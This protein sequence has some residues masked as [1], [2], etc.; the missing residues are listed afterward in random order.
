MKNPIQIA[1]HCINF[2]KDNSQLV[3]LYSNAR[4]TWERSGELFLKNAEDNA[5]LPRYDA[6]ELLGLHKGKTTKVMAFGPSLRDSYTEI[7]DCDYV[8]GCDRGYG[9]YRDHNIDPDLIITMDAK[10]YPEYIG[11][12]NI[13]GRVLL[14]QATSNHNFCKEWVNRGGKV[15]FYT[16]SCIIKSHEL[17]KNFFK[18]ELF[19]LQAMSNVACGLLVTCAELLKSNKLELYGYDHS[20][21]KEW[22]YPDQ[23]VDWNKLSK[24]PKLYKTTGNHNEECFF[25]DAMY[26]YLYHMKQI[27][28]YYK[29]DV[30]NKSPGILKL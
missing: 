6:R 24:R 3:A 16:V 26:C 30:E 22:M 14:A 20:W 15:Y 23:K 19:H 1:N 7:L 13:E 17:Y 12:H 5:K 9:W 4:A 21:Q 18:E 28:Q 27:I 25:T 11:D 29:L 8:I 10:M 2:Y